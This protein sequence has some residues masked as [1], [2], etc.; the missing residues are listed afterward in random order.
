MSPAFQTVIA[1]GL[2]ALAAILLLRSYLKKRKNPGCGSESCSAVTPAIRD[3]K[4]RLK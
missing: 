4:S 1:L 2:V 3:L